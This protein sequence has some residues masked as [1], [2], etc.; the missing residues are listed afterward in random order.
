MERRKLSN[1]ET[2]NMLI[3]MLKYVDSFCTENSI[4]YYL[5]Y[6]TLLGAVRHN[7]FIPWDD[8]IDIIMPRDSFQKLTELF[9]GSSSRYRLESIYTN[10]D[11]YFPLAKI[12]D[13]RTYLRQKGFKE[14]TKLGLYIDVFILDGMPDDKEEQKRIYELSNVYYKKCWRTALTFRQEGNSFI[15][16][17]LRYIKRLNEHICGCK[18]YLKKL[19]KISK[20]YDFAKSK[21]VCNLNYGVYYPKEIYEKEM[22]TSCRHQF[23]N[24]D[25]IIPEGYDD[26]LKQIYGDWRKLPPENQRVGIHDYECYLIK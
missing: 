5:F 10:N 12:I 18:Y 14:K 1:E 3:S 17:C 6:G 24:I 15:K 25:C 11:Y 19:D 8:D 22:F 23:E 20:S 7:G 9:N 26:I 13:N 2:K 4:T 16:D 21:Y